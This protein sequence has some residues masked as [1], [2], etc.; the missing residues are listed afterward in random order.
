MKQ[1]SGL[2]KNRNGQALVSLLMF[3]VVALTVITSTITTV[4]SNTASASIE[5]QSIDAY[6]T[7]ES[8]AENALMRLLRDPTYTGETL[9]VGN[10][11]ATV[12]VSGST[13]V[14]TGRA[15]NLTRKIQVEVSYTNNQM[16]VISWKE[17]P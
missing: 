16:T 2:E 9:P 3:I 7:A 1:S 5:Q 12:T 6:Y 4:I 17:I 11:S 13:I 10:N 8:G 15:N 14:S